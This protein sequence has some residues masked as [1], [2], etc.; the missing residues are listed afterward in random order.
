MAARP[1]PMTWAE[2][3]SIFMLLEERPNC[4]VKIDRVADVERRQ[5]CENISLDGT[6]Q[7][8]ERVDEDDEDE[9]QRRNAVAHRGLAVDP[10]D[11]EIAEHVEQDMA[12]EHGDERPE[13]E[14]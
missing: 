6:Y 12:G 7:Q 2:A 3:S 8:L 1:A 10:L 11:D 13:A 14:A 5:Q 9:G 4:L